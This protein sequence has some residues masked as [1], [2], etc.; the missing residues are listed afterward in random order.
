[1][2]CFAYC[3]LLKKTPTKK[4]SRLRQS[5]S[6]HRAG[7]GCMGGICAALA[8]FVCGMWMVHLVLMLEEA[9]WLR[10]QRGKRTIHAAVELVAAGGA[11]RRVPLQVGIAATNGVHSV[12][13]GMQNRTLGPYSAH[14]FAGGGLTRLSRHGCGAHHGCAGAG[15]GATWQPARALTLSAAHFVDTPGP[16]PAAGSGESAARLGGGSLL[17]ANLAATE[18]VTLGLSA[19]RHASHAAHAASYAADDG[20]A[21]RGVGGVGAAERDTQTS[22]ASTSLSFTGGAP[23]VP[24]D[25]HVMVLLSGSSMCRNEPKVLCL[26]K[27]RL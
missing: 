14:A 4:A 9:D 24:L 21:F 10:P 7:L 18:E 2:G 23:R 8:Q 11:G 26:M 17:A 6:L 22:E 3:F 20:L 1:M 15:V 12:V 27:H 13:F 5:G 19:T 25:K 16:G